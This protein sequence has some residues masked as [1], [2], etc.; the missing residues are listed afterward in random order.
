MKGGGN[1]F[2]GNSSGARGNPHEWRWPRIIHFE[3]VA[4]RALKASTVVLSS[5][6]MSIQDS[7][8]S[9]SPH[10]AASYQ[11]V[12]DPQDLLQHAGVNHC[13][14][15]ANLSGSEQRIAS[16]EILMKAAPEGACC[17]GPGRI[18]QKFYLRFLSQP[19]LRRVESETPFSEAPAPCHRLGDW[20]IPRSDKACGKEAACTHALSQ[21]TTVSYTPVSVPV[22]PRYIFLLVFGATVAERLAHSP[23]TKENRAQ[24]PVGP[25]PDFRVW[26]SCPDDATS[27]RVFSG[28]SRLPRHF[29]PALLHTPLS[30]PHLITH[31]TH[32]YRF[33]FFP[34]NGTFTFAE[35]TIFIST[36][37]SSLTAELSGTAF[38][39]AHFTVNGIYLM[40]TGAGPS[41]EMAGSK[42]E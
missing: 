41:W 28:I 22:L 36:R 5:P 3:A 16:D 9:V 37:S 7:T 25:L 42:L 4:G 38:K 10:S 15:K 35:D 34:L 6:L 2:W 39:S 31:F 21:M 27:W 11:W 13:L 20:P 19:R 12:G 29:I 1:I 32:L 14:H 26:E 33:V 8:E 17:S 18:S 23:F 40:E 24:S 30:H